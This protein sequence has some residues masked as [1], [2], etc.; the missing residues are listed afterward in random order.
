MDEILLSLIY[1]NTSVVTG[2]IHSIQNVR[3]LKL[4]V[5]QIN[6]SKELLKIDYYTSLPKVDDGD[7]TTSNDLTPEPLLDKSEK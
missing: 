2:D 7:E 1:L 4:I 5:N 3:Y 6:M